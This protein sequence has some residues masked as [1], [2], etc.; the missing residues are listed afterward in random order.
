MA[1]VLQSLQDHSHDT[2]TLMAMSFSQS[3]RTTALRPEVPAPLEVKLA[4]RSVGHAAR[5]LPQPQPQRRHHYLEPKQSDLVVKAEQRPPPPIETTPS[6]VSSLLAFH[7]GDERPPSSSLRV[8]CHVTW[9]ASTEDLPRST[10]YEIQ[11]RFVLR[12]LA[13]VNEWQ[14]LGLI[15][16]G[17]GGDGDGVEDAHGDTSGAFVGQSTTT[18][19][20]ASPTS[21]QQQQQRQQAGCE[22]MKV[23]RRRRLRP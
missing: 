11:R 23:G 2:T 14:R 22:M 4:Y 13:Q 12:P 20:S 10:Q 7:L 15:D 5:L 21:L 9:P 18:G 17:G 8:L 1:L 19:G 16:E 3:C 6:S